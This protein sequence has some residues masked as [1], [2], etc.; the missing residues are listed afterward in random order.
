MA[1][2][3]D[4]DLPQG[5]DRET[6]PPGSIARALTEENLAQKTWITVDNRNAIFMMLS[7]NAY[8]EKYT[9]RR[10][11]IID[12]MVEH[13]VVYNKSLDGQSI[14]AIIGF[15]AAA[16]QAPQSNIVIGESMTKKLGG[17]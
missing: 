15:A 7:F 5:V 13:A 16:N 1:D 17:T 9:G 12:I 4:F 11:T 6:T 14:Q 3:L 8:L 10:S 2:E